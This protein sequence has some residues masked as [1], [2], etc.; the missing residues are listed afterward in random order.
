MPS[1]LAALFIAAAF[2]LGTAASLQPSAATGV[3]SLGAACDDNRGP[4]VIEGWM[5]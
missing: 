5:F 1:R 2:V 3:T 4:C